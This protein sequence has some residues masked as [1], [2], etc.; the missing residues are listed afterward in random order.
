M[1]SAV[2]VFGIYRRSMS[3]LFVVVQTADYIDNVGN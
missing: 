3:F 1:S 2:F